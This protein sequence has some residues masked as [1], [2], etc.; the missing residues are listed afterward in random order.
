MGLAHTLVVCRART[1]GRQLAMPMAKGFRWTARYADGKG[2]RPYNAGTRFR[3]LA[4][5]SLLTAKG[6]TMHC[7]L[8]H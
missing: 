7:S 1:V 6:V 5:L 8:T 3:Q 4:M 2:I